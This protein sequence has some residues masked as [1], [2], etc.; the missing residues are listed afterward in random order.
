MTDLLKALESAP[1]EKFASGKK[2]SKFGQR[3]EKPC[4][5]RIIMFNFFTWKNKERI[6]RKTDAQNQQ[7]RQQR[8]KPPKKTYN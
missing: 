3:Q 5:T 6:K 1:V 4:Q 8:Q 2:C 7:Q